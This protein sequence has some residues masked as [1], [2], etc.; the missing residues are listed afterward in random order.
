MPP[1]YVMKLSQVP[2]LFVVL[3]SFVITSIISFRFSFE[4]NQS[5]Y[6]D[7]ATKWYQC[8]V[9]NA[10]NNITNPAFSCNANTTMLD[11]NRKKCGC[12]DQ[13][14]HMYELFP[15]IALASVAI[16]AN[17]IF[18]AITFGLLHHIAT[19][20]R[21]M[22]RPIC[23]HTARCLYA[24]SDCL[25]NWFCCC[26]FRRN[27]ENE[28]MSAFLDEASTPERNSIMAD[29]L[30]EG[31]T[32]ERLVEEDI[33][34]RR[35]E[36][37]A[38]LLVMGGDLD[39]SDGAGYNYQNRNHRRSRSSRRGYYKNRNHSRSSSGKGPGGVGDVW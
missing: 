10:E 3:F 31:G 21:Y 11:G 26:C 13:I 32:F 39:D 22:C 38:G 16:N 28:L 20:V 35:D 4:V 24:I 5:E 6:E 30:L 37:S 29:T 7:V 36:N 34:K 17:G 2:V 12:G 1:I 25:K 19:F 9:V 33:R 15:E 14:P 23:K 18:I 8:L 27:E